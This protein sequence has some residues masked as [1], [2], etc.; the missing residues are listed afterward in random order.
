MCF[1]R[2]FSGYN[3]AVRGL[4]H[5]HLRKRKAAGTHPY[6]AKSQALRML[7]RV[8]LLGGIIGPMTAIPQVLKIYLLKDAAGVSILS[9]ALPAVLD[10]PWIVYGV[11]HR[12]RPIAVT[13]AL[14]FLAN[15]A[16][17][18]GVLIY[19]NGSL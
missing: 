15:S 17:A 13:Y 7:D 10:V 4:H 6:P 11:Y 1:S 14:W 12:E 8:V 5:L 16:V 19:G 2:H 18:L 3:N 9:W